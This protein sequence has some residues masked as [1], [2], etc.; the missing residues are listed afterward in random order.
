MPY[1]SRQTVSR[2]TLSSIK[3]KTVTLS[4]Q[5]W[6]EVKLAFDIMKF[7]NTNKLNFE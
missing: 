5:K 3:W 6:S 1:L 2:Q 4:D 7:V